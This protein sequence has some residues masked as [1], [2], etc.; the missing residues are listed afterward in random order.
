MFKKGIKIIYY[1]YDFIEK[2]YKKIYKINNSFFIM[3]KIYIHATIF[4]FL[5]L[6]LNFVSKINFSIKDFIIYNIE[7]IFVILILYFIGFLILF[8]DKDKKV[9]K[10]SD[11]EWNIYKNKVAYHITSKN[12]I[13][14]IKTKEGIYLKPTIYNLANLNVFFND[15]VYMFSKFPTQEEILYQGLK[16]KSDIVLEIPIKNLDRKKLRK[17]VN[18]NV[19]VYMDKYIGEGK[20]KTINIDDYK[21][22]IKKT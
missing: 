16:N 3:E 13:N 11:E 1:L 4:L 18:K 14:S 8:F 7:S 21:N 2:F 20:I 22:K 12:N 9:R 6:N 5:S 17:R 15:S 10:L 19:F